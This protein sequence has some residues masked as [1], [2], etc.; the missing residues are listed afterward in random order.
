M[1]NSARLCQLT[2]ISFG[3]HNTPGILGIPNRVTA[4]CAGQ[5]QPRAGSRTGSSSSAPATMNTKIV[6]MPARWV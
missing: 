3:S 6:A 4:N 2:P 5:G 1:K